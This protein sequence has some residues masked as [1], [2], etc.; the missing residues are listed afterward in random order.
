V[1][2]LVTGGAGFLGSHLV[3][4]LLAEGHAVDVLDDLSTGRLS[5][6]ADARADRAAEL[7]IH[8]VDVRGREVVDLIERR[9]PDVVFH[10]AG[11]EQRDPVDGSAAT[12][13][14]ALHVLEGARLA[15]AGKVVV[16]LDADIY[17]DPGDDQLPL[18][19]SHPAEPVTAHGVA[20]LAVVEYLRLYREQHGVDFT[21]LVLGTVFGPRQAG[22]VLGRAA[23]DLLAGKTPVATAAARDLL[24]V[25]DAVDAVVRAGERAGGLLLNVGWGR[26][27]PVRDVIATMAEAAG[28]PEVSPGEGE[29]L[30][31]PSSIA[32]DGARARIHLGWAPWTSVEEGIGALLRWVASTT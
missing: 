14:A 11:T 15:K 24:Y 4:R 19:E 21:A 6:L 32:L 29:P 16:V 13:L 26:A 12:I 18:K 2:A 1:K 31:G 28:R 20:G 22:G 30:A 9:Q 27:V 25:D 17:G 3:D 10:L 23:V 7:R 5:N 8:Q